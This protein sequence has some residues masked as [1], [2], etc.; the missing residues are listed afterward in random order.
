MSC[1]ARRQF[2]HVC[3]NVRREFWV[4][5]RVL[6]GAL[7]MLS[8]LAVPITSL[9]AMTGANANSLQMSSD[10]SATGWYSNEPRLSPATVRGG[11]FGELFDTQLSGA[12]YAQPLVRQATAL[13][14]TEKDLAYGV[15]ANTGAILWKDNFGPTAEPFSQIGCPVTG[16]ELGITGTPVIDPSTGI[17][18]FVAA[19]NTGTN[20]ATQWFMEAVNSR[21]GAIAPGWPKNGVL[22]Q[23]SADKDSATVFNG[24]YEMQRPGLVLVHGVVYAAFGAM[25]DLDSWEGWL[26]G[27]SESSASITTMWSSEEHVSDTGTHQPGAGIWQS[28]S[29]PVVNGEG[30]IFVATGNGDVPSKPVPGNDATAYTYGEAV[31]ELSTSGGILRPIDFFIA[32]DAK[33]LNKQDGELGS[34]GPVALPV[35]MGTKQEPN[36]MLVDGKQ[37]I[38]YVLNQNDLG[39]YKQGPKGTDNVPAEVGPNWGVWAKPAVWPG[40][41]GYVYIPTA[42]TS[43]F[44]T[45][46]GSLNAFKRTV[47]P[48]GVVSFTLAGAT[49]YGG[50][51]FG[52]GSGSPIVTSN[53]TKSGSALVWIVHNISPSGVE[54]QLQAYNSVPV[55]N[56]LL[57]EVWSSAPFTSNVFVQPGVN[58]G[59]VY[60]GTQDQTLLAFGALHSRTPALTGSSVSFPADII[61]QSVTKDATFTA[62]E[63]TTVSSFTVSGSY[64]MGAA[65]VSLPVSLAKGQSIT[66]PI[67]FTPTTL[68]ANLGTLTANITGAASTITLT[69]QG[70]TP[71][72]SFTISPNEANFPPELIGGHPSKPVRITFTNVSSTAIKVTGFSSPI[73][74]FVV[75]D[76]PDKQ[77]VRP[78][79]G[80]LTFEVQFRPPPSSGD[81]V[82]VFNSFATLETSAGDFGIAITG[83]ADPPATLNTAPDVL[84]FGKVAVGSSETLIYDLGDL[85]GF[86]LRIIRSTPPRSSGFRAITN[87]F[88]QL[89]KTSPKN[90]IAP[91][92]SVQEKVRFAPTKNGYVTATWLLEGN[93]GNGVQKVTFTGT[94]YTP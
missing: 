71:A 89:S 20:G 44:A 49:A 2:P 19:R 33:V 69:G 92:T 87:P 21:S 42:G 67:T 3:S 29:P 35:S 72:A 6:V 94:G 66:I 34:G 80:T 56:S 78:N 24:Q 46:G 59:I 81:F 25:C 79:G 62:S 36:V 47:K 75:S 39:G 32:A 53:G 38:L 65:S 74:P 31:I 43:A 63:H 15:N 58:N 37:G 14:V 45:D 64:S 73:L 23:G 57:E 1:D 41:G 50:N 54:S 18:Y 52:F 7:L 76:R 12:I 51:V 83:S 70:E 60:V 86:P 8:A 61:S 85:G 55:K 28:G 22:I 17:A 16:L 91:N 77:M 93:D 9:L 84:N 40:D 26:V 10:S 4:R 48:N 27:V 68:G 5:T 90:T 82:H 13:V 88:S 30:D 11:N